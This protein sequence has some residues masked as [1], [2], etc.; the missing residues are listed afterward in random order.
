MIGIS[1]FLG[2][3][4]IELLIYFAA[5]RIVFTPPLPINEIIDDYECRKDT[6]MG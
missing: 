5:S 2:S 4:V 6:L 1:E 3:V